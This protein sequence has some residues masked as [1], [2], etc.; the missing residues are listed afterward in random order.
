MKGAITAAGGDLT[1]LPIDQRDHK[2]M[3]AAI[4]RLKEEKR[5]A[6]EEIQRLNLERD[7][8]K[9]DFDLI[10]TAR[11]SVVVEKDKRVRWKRRIG[12]GG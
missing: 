3:A 10:N 8:L 7:S 11:D 2:K 5:S 4:E 9:S 6:E 1:L 12:G